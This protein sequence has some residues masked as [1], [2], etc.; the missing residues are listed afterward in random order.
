MLVGL[1]LEGFSISFLI[2]EVTVIK[3]VIQRSKYYHSELA[4]IPHIFNCR[5]LTPTSLPYLCGSCNSSLKFCGKYFSSPFTDLKKKKFW[6]TTF[7]LTGWGKSAAFICRTGFHRGVSLNIW[8]LYFGFSWKFAYVYCMAMC[9]LFGSS[10]KSYR[11]G[12]KLP[13]ITSYPTATLFCL[14]DD[15]SYFY[16][17]QEI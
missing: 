11:V 8:R 9:C 10:L 3:N 7:I 16:S 13:S 6:S 17:T 2:V 1:L 12:L 4:L 15:V 5:C 14:H